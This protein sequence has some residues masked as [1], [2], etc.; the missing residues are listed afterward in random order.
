MR[1]L[2]LH[3]VVQPI[4][5]YLRRFILKKLFFTI[6]DNELNDHLIN[7]DTSNPEDFCEKLNICYEEDK[8]ESI[9]KKNY[10]FYKKICSE[11]SFKTAYTKILDEFD[12]LIK[13]WK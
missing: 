13:R 3:F 11:D 2:C 12:H 4:C 9:T 6:N 1:L 8:I 10:E 7:I 5:Q